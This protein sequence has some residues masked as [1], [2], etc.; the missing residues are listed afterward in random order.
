MLSAV[1]FR[2]SNQ[3][4][5]PISTLTEGGVRLATD[6][7][8][9]DTRRADACLLP[10]DWSFAPAS[11]RGTWVELPSFM[12]GSTAATLEGAFGDAT[13]RK[14]VDHSGIVIEI[15]VVIDID[16]AAGFAADDPVS[17][18]AG[19][20]ERW[21]EGPESYNAGYALTKLNNRIDRS[22]RRGRF[23]DRLRPN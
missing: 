23:K 10:A 3:P 14:G 6:A 12:D 13:L 2:L 4:N 11:A 8:R 17:S 19:E 21:M 18:F 15:D 5:K 22:R 16:Y 7:Y 9:F 20:A 1:L